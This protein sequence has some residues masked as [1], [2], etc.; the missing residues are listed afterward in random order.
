LL[1]CSSQLLIL[2]PRQQGQTI[3]AH[4][5][6][7]SKVV[8]F[9]GTI[10]IFTVVLGPV[11]SQAAD[12]WGR[13]WF[14]VTL[15]FVGAVGSVL[16]S[17]ASSL[18]MAIAG[19][20]LIGVAFG[21]QPLLHVV[22][23]EVLP[24]RWRGLAQA[25]PIVFS[26][27]GSLV[28]LFVGA[29][30]NR[31][32]NPN[33]DGFRSYFYM[34]MACFLLSAVICA[35][36]YNPPPLPGQLAFTQREKLAKL[37]WLGYLLLTTGLVLFS[38]G[39]SYSKNPYEW[40][41]PCVSATFAVGLALSLAMV[42]YETW[43]KK[44]GLF[45]HGLFSRNRNFSIACLAVFLEGLAFFA[46]NSYF[47]FQVGVLYEQQDAMLV[48]VRYSFMPIFNALFGCVA[49]WYC[50]RTRRVRW[51]TV[52]AFVLLVV[53]FVCMA[54]SDAGS[55]DAVW[56]YAVLMGVSFGILLTT[57]ITLA[58]LSTP[59]EL[60]SIASGLFIGVRSLGANVGLAIY[61]AV[62][63][64]AMS[65]LGQNVADAVVP[66]GLAVGDLPAF[67]AALVNH[68]DTALLGIRGVTPEM[69]DSGVTALLDTYVVSFRHVWITAGCFVVVAAIG[70][71]SLKDCS[72]MPC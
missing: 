42:A 31:N 36:V 61:N 34:A 16:I 7:T 20:C 66:E 25:C 33:S 60:I 11:V 12:Y 24:R 55:D 10:A 64:E 67:V 3:G 15:T 5:N 56:G 17:R 1:S 13:K 49:G 70:K 18:N 63:N 22:A 39:L 28:G 62:F 9:A 51:I 21:T 23:S 35:L 37:D 53:F 72:S 45:H 8:W 46:A 50:T 32:S 43:Y 47:A 41:D 19:F 4:F 58:Q 44:D 29:A 71:L 52:A 48:A 65:R 59:P 2:I 14:L 57:L 54:T 40:S 69:I 68:N 6:D 38:V 27:L 30:L 26:V